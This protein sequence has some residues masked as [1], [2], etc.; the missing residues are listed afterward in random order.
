MTSAAPP[1]ANGT[2]IRTGRSGHSAAGAA[3][4]EN[5]LAERLAKI[6]A[7]RRRSRR[8]TTSRQI[9][10]RPKGLRRSRMAI[11]PPGCNVSH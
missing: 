1:A 2:M 9:G 5:R 11:L 10:K 6:T 7:A 4:S 8:R 3:L